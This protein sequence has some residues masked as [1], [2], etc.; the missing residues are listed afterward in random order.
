[1]SVLDD[2]GIVKIIDGILR[3]EGSSYSDDPL[4]G[5]GPT[6]WG[7]T[8]RALCEYLILIKAPIPH[9]AVGIRTA[10]WEL[11]RETAAAIYGMLYVIKPGFIDIQDK[12]LRELVVDT[13]VLHGRNRASRWLQ[14][15]VD[16]TP[17]GIVGPITLETVNYA[18]PRAVYAQLLTRRYQGFADFIHSKPSQLR[19]LKGWMN[20]ANEFTLRLV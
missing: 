1:M 9:T 16:V 15:V 11:S 8:G 3:R 14:M 20:R 18:K 13:G 7:I 6:R 5:G 12:D 17:D 19:F 2:P 10:I 4:D